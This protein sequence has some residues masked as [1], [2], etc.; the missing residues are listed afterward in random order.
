[1]WLGTALG[2]LCGLAWGQRAL[3]LEGHAVDPFASASGK[4]V[5]LIFLRRDCPISGRYA[6]V[7]QKISSEYAATPRDVFQ[8]VAAAENVDLYNDFTGILV[9]DGIQRAIT[10]DSD[11]TNKDSG[12]YGFLN[13][14]GDL[15]LMS[16]DSS[17]TEEGK[18]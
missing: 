17:K 9:V 16:R 5:V 7:I 8:L 11:R 15:S 1:M 10:W 13:Q 2:V 3:D 12:F 6:P 14:I 4:P 18:L